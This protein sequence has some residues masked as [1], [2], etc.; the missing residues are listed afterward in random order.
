MADYL[1]LRRIGFTQLA[2]HIMG[3]FIELKAKGRKPLPS[4]I[5]WAAEMRRLGFLVET[6]DDLDSFAA[7]YERVFGRD[8]IPQ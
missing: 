1:A 5:A 7:Y 3:I 8:G 2:G 6:V 4:Q